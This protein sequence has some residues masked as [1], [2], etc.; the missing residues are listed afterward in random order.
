[1]NQQVRSLV[2]K[3][4]K[5]HIYYC[6]R[7]GGFTAENYIVGTDDNYKYVVKIIRNGADVYFEKIACLQNIFSGKNSKIF[8]H[9]VCVDRI[10]NIIIFPFVEGQVLHGTDILVRYDKA[11]ASV[12]ARLH[13]CT[14]LPNMPHSADLYLNLATS[15]KQIQNLLQ[16]VPTTDEYYQI[17]NDILN[18][19]C[20]I[21]HKYKKDEDLIT[22]VKS[23]NDFVHGDFHNENILFSKYGINAV[24]DFELAHYGNKAEDIINFAWFA[25]L[26]ND[27]SDKN[28]K[29]AAKFIARCK[30]RLGAS[31]TDLQ[32]AFKLTF[33]R[34]VQSSVLEKSLFEF[35]EPFYK[36]LLDRDFKKFRE[37]DTNFTAIKDKL[38]ALC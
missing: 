24:L 22:W 32:N 4:L 30:D 38:L 3:Q 18:L 21:L 14:H 28:M 8:V 13:K 29:R 16:S 27:F 20:N 11:V 9:P 37:I 1:M 31:N 5:A 19:K 34:F 17:I 10:H 25:F 26:N 15:E 6:E 7:A 35:R 36:V 33:L 23:S 12:L 2:E